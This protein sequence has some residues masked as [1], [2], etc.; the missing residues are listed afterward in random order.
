PA[1]SIPTR[2]SSDL[3]RA[4]RSRFVIPEAIFLGD[5]MRRHLSQVDAMTQIPREE[6]LSA[7][8]VLTRPLRHA[9]RGTKERY[10]RE[11]K[12]AVRMD[13]HRDS[14]SLGTCSPLA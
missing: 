13:L 8:I 4:I 2:R 5:P 6:L 12:P 1:P 3:L 7:M 11:A 10:N 14:S 9:P